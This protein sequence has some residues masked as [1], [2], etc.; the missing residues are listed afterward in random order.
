MNLTSL[1]T[2]ARQLRLSGLC[3]NLE[4][5]LH[6]ATTHQLPPAQFLEL[7]F[8]D[9]LNIRHSRTLH[10]RSQQA[11]FRE[12]RSL[13]TFDFSF[14]PS[15]S[16]S[17]I[18][19]LATSQYLREHRDILFIGPPGTG[20]SHLAQALGREAIKAG[21]TSLYRSVFDLAR[22]LADTSHQ[23]AERDKALQRYLRTDLLILDDMGMRTLSQQAT[24]HLLEIIM[25][26]YEL[27]STILTSNR[28][29]DQWGQLLGDQPTATAILDRILHRAEII[30]ITGRSYR[31]QQAVQQ[32]T[33]PTP[34][35]PATTAEPT[36]TAPVPPVHPI[37]PPVVPPTTKTPK[38]AKPPST[39]K[40]KRSDQA[41]PAP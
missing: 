18:Y 2:Q 17:Q 28:P 40:P 37:V 3:E 33:G 19:N 10:R 22:D 38:P 35:P 31:L 11:S 36:S 34:A 39:I 23:P 15:L 16:R 1:K 5:R 4:L 7:L 20:K 27:R 41:S 12:Q 13:D 8:Q 24:E 21:Y 29:V 26:R 30:H 25:R 32:R 6:E 9:E 14:Q